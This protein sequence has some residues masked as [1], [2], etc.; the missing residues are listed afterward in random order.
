MTNVSCEKIK[1]PLI[2]IQI[3]FFEGYKRHFTYYSEQ[4]TEFIAT[5][6][7]LS[8]IV[9]ISYL[10]RALPRVEYSFFFKKVYMQT[11]MT[12]FCT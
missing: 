6:K 5:G 7:S 4:Y 3:I 1:I 12:C 10:T 11:F 8:L 9:V 2:L